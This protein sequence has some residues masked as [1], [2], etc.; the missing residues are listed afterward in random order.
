MEKQI[1]DEVQDVQKI[2]EIQEELKE[3]EE[4]KYKGAM[5]RSKAKYLVD[6]QSFFLI[7]KKKEEQK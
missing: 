7:W 6:V 3:I 5:L 4:N 1:D 2:K